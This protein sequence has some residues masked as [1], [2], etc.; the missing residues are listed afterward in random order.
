[1]VAVAAA[2]LLGVFDERQRISTAAESPPP[3]GPI[4]SATPI[5]LPKAPTRIVE[6][7][8]PKKARPPSAKKAKA[9]A[10]ETSAPPPPHA[11]PPARPF[12]DKLARVKAAPTSDLRFELADDIERAADK[13]LDREAAA[14]VKACLTQFR[15]T[16]GARHLEQCVEKFERARG[17][18]MTP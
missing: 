14:G 10:P 17:S 15:I 12:A 2:Y 1:V 18:V 4:P 7:P 8:Q 11:L 13:S 16:G 3:A 5:V 6:L 9:I